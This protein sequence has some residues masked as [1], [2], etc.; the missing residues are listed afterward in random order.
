MN[1]VVGKLAGKRERSSPAGRWD[2]KPA[3]LVAAQ[4]T[5][6]AG[7]NAGDLAEA[8]A[9]LP[10]HQHVDQTADWLALKLGGQLALGGRLGSAPPCLWLCGLLL[11]QLHAEV[12]QVE[13]HDGGGGAAPAWHGWMGESGA[14]RDGGAELHLGGGPGASA[15]QLQAPAAVGFLPQSSPIDAAGHSRLRTIARRAVAACAENVRYTCSVWLSGLALISFLG[16]SL[17]AANAGTTT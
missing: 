15:A 13:R 11:L 8:G 2:I 7:A 16:L 14:G 1:Q 17:P 9:A 5:E 12:H 3:R 10:Q 4:H 6:A